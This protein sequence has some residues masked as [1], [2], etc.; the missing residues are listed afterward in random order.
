MPAVAL[1]CTKAIRDV[2]DPGSATVEESGDGAVGP[3]GGEQLDLRLPERQRGDRRPVGLFR[4]VGNHAE[5]VAVEG[6]RGFEVRYGHA[7]MRNPGAISH[8][9]PPSE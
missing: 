7:N 9:I 3:E 2:V 1:G 5:D 6:Q 4:G 8:A